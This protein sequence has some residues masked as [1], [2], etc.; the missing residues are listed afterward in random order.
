MKNP[1]EKSPEAVLRD[2]YV[3]ALKETANRYLHPIL[4][5]HYFFRHNCPLCV[6]VM[7]CCHNCPLNIASNFNIGCVHHKNIIN[8]QKSFSLNEMGISNP[9]SKKPTIA[10]KERAKQL[11][12]CA[13]AIAKMPIK[14]F[15][16]K[17][18]SKIYKYVS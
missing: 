3:K 18:F 17:D 6:T 10:M 8:L 14:D 12:N 4:N 15:I 7:G 2:E 5:G 16:K 9:L 13:N 1:K 11:I